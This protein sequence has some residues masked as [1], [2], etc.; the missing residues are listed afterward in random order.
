[1]LPLLKAEAADLAESREE[2]QVLLEDAVA[3][4][5]KKGAQLKPILDGKVDALEWLK[6]H[7]AFALAPEGATYNAACSRSWSRH[8]HR[9]AAVF[10]LGPDAVDA[11]KAVAAA[12]AFYA[13]HGFESRGKIEPF[14]WGY[15][16]KDD[17]VAASVME[18]NHFFKH[19][20][21]GGMGPGPTVVLAAGG[22]KLE[23][24][25]AGVPVE[26]SQGKALAAQL[27]ASRVSAEEYQL[28][29]VRAVIAREAM[30]ELPAAVEG[31]ESPAAARVRRKQAEAMGPKKASAEAY[32]RHAAE[33]TPYLGD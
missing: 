17:S 15:E 30:S 6:G 9:A 19:A 12:R 22:R 10:D 8:M 24:P 32:R 31:K 16:S 29:R 11:P 14:N 20:E 5:E 26:I 13:A 18:L 21:C 4:D 28:F 27:R 25:Q 1:M 23:R 33:L 2:L 3:H 7:S